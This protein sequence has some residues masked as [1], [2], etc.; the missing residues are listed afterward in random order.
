MKVTFLW[1]LGGL[2]LGGIIHIVSVLWVPLTAENDSWTQLAGFGPVN[3]LHTIAPVGDRRPPLPDMDPSLRYAV[4]RYDLTNGPLLISG[5]VPLV[6]WSVA[7]YDRRGLNYYALNDRLVAGRSI[8]LWVATK[9]Q[10]LAIEPQSPEAEANDER[11]LIGAPGALGF[12]VFR[13]LVPGPSFEAAV[14]ETFASTT[15]KSFDALA[16]VDSQG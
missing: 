9:Q 3:A 10:L 16:A 2:M 13:V 6:Y 7:L 8:K 4:C 12:A 1:A 11:L 14:A 15:C 5:E